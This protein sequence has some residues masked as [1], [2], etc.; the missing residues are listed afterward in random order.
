MQKRP[1]HQNRRGGNRGPVP[2][3]PCG[4]RTSRDRVVVVGP[5]PI[6]GD[7]DGALSS[8]RARWDGRRKGAASGG[9]LVERT[10]FRRSGGGRGQA[11]RYGIR[12]GATHRFNT[13]E[14]MGTFCRDREMRSTSR[15][16]RTFRSA[17][18]R[19]KERIIRIGVRAKGS[20]FFSE[21]SA[22]SPQPLALISQRALKGHHKRR[23]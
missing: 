1:G 2:R 12:S 16:V 22:L 17:R 13:P 5:R 3:A 8:E 15:V 7:P 23:K 9:D 14:A 21:R 20:G 10:R 11:Q 19:P 6:H 4:R 18:R